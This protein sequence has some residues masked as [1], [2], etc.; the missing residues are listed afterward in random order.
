MR[1]VWL[2][3]AL[4]V[5]AVACSGKAVVDGVSADGGS[6]GTSSSSSNNGPTTVVV[7]VASSSGSTMTTS[8]GTTECITCGTWVQ[9]CIEG[10]AACDDTDNFCG[11]AAQ[12]AFD[13]FVDCICKECGDPCAGTCSGGGTDT[14][15][16][17]DC[18]QAAAFGSC[19]NELS[20]CLN[21]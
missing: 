6:G 20:D 2:F 17:G 18:Q 3:G 19:E 11:G 10:N 7:S 5:V 14:Q 9:G 4:V 21:N 16:C 13:D 1:T 12:N 15:D 8:S